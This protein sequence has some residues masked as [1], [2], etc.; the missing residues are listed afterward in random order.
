MLP[1]NVCALCLSDADAVMPRNN[2]D[3][4]LTRWSGRGLFLSTRRSERRRELGKYE[5]MQLETCA[6]KNV[7]HEFEE[8]RAC[9]Q[10]GT[11]VSHSERC[12][13]CK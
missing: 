9:G 3:A 4:V 2:P 5:G 8:Q 12:P 13:C 7:D 6:E 11:S 10:I 1:A